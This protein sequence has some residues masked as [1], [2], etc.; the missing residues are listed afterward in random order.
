MS[1]TDDTNTQTI[2]I[3]LPQ[4]SNLS[5]NEQMTT[6]SVD[7][8]L[9]EE[10]RLESNEDKVINESIDNSLQQQQQQH[11]QQC[12]QSYYNYYSAYNMSSVMPQTYPYFVPVVQPL[13]PVMPS[14]QPSIQ[15]QKQ[16]IVPSVNSKVDNNDNYDNEEEEEDTDSD[17]T[18]AK[19]RP[20]KASNVLPIHCND[21][22]GLNP[23]IYTNIQQSPYFKNNLFQLK[24]YHEVIDEIY[25]SVKHLE[26]WEKGSRKVFTPFFYH[27]SHYYSLILVFIQTF[28]T[29]LYINI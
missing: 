4:E 23:L 12:Y 18:V 17:P 22:M 9:T 15:Q 1:L 25:Y 13:V 27:Y 19:A 11:Q 29:F 6:T 24:T 26:P 7:S 20:S 8:T 16:S 14:I 2:D 28:Q 3:P 21:K 10:K 5:S